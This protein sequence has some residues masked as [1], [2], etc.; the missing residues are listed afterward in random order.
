MEPSRYHVRRA[1]LDDLAVLKGLW[2][3][4][5]LPGLELEKHLTEFQLAVRPDG[6]VAGVVGLRAGGGQGLV[7][8]EAFPSTRQGE[9][10]RPA[11][12][13]RLQ[14]L[15]RNQALVRLWTRDGPC[16][17][18]RDQ[19][20]RPATREELKTLPSLFGSQAGGWLTLVLREESLLRRELGE[21]LARLHEQEVLRTE[22]LRRQALMI[23]WVAGAMAIGFFA[24]AVW[25]MFDVLWKTR[26]RRTEP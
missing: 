7:H 14:A 11:L 24:A 5:R 25:L 18:W 3:V 17:F 6:V 19:G 9:E 2:Q 26:P 21:E 15:A 8:G 1:N 23:K 22:R 12:W 13:E 16:A 10:V 20:F 4:A